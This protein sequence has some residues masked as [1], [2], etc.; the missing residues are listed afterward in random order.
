MISVV[1]SRLILWRQSWSTCRWRIFLTGT[2]KSP[3]IL[4]YSSS[5]KIRTSTL[6]LNWLDLMTQIGLNMSWVKN[7]FLS[8]SLYRDNT[9]KK[10][11]SNSLWTLRIKQIPLNRRYKKWILRSWLRLR[12]IEALSHK[13]RRQQI[14]S[15]LAALPNFRLFSSHHMSRSVKL[16]KIL[17]RIDQIWRK[18][19]VSLRVKLL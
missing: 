2:L 5:I 17:L 4:A 12:G 18:K 6:Y 1:A 14:W 16:R 9:L 10:K 15:L 11:K 19:S 3:W 7:R 13:H 8:F